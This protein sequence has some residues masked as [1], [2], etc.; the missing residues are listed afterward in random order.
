MSGNPASPANSRGRLRFG[1][2]I[3]LAGLLVYILGAAP[4]LLG[5]DRSPMT[6]FVQI[7]VFLVGLGMICIGGY[8][9]LNQFWKGSEKTIAADI[10]L[11]LVSTGYVI[12]FASGLADV[13]GFGSHPFRSG[14]RAPSIPYFGP[15]QATGVIIGEVV[16][17]IGF[18]LL[19]HYPQRHKSEEL[20]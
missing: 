3:L 17:I 6:G 16:I 9:V 12:S 2:I 13:F 14:A 10:G 1:L 20:D 11:R 8:A 4:A 18:L 15:L 5:V 7:S 19:I